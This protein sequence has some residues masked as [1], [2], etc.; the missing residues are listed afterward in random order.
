MTLPRDAMLLRIFIG[1]HEKTQGRRPLGEAIVLKAREAHLAGATMLRGPYLA[2][3]LEI[4][5]SGN[6]LTMCRE[7]QAPVTA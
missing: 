6:S 5:R 3:P 4:F 1:E 7:G 2:T